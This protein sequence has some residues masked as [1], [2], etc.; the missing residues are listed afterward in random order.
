VP[1]L[2]LPYVLRPIWRWPDRQSRARAPP[3]KNLD[4]TFGAVAAL[5]LFKLA[6]ATYIRISAEG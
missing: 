3:P 4:I 1:Q 6:A 2:L 5:V